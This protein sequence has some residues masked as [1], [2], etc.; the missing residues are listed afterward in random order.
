MTSLTDS[1]AAQQRTLEDFDQCYRQTLHGHARDIAELADKV[2]ARARD[3]EAAIR[4]LIHDQTLA[5]QHLEA[6][7]GVAYDPTGK[8]R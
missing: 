8:S 1:I 4:R 6:E 5:L 7:P 2:A 3:D